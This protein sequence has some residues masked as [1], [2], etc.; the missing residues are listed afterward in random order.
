MV[1][2]YVKRLT[3]LLLSGL[4][5]LSVAAFQLPASPAAAADCGGGPCEGLDPKTTGCINDPDKY[6]LG[7]FSFTDYRQT[8]VPP[9]YGYG[10]F[11]Y[12][13][14]CHAVWGNYNTNDAGDSHQLALYKQAV[15][16]GV[17]QAVVVIGSHGPDEYFTTMVSWDSSVKFCG[18]NK[19]LGDPDAYANA[20]SD[21]KCTP[22]H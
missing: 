6:A 18:Q 15:Y 19:T 7:G 13:P 4:S 17:E 22:S 21:Y 20:T 11:W 8:P 10:D 12:S 2:D 14:A 5:L 1:G 9:P 3:A 16:G